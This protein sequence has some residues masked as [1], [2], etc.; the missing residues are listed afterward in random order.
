MI[1]IIPNYHPIL[2]HFTVA[3]FSTSLG[4]H[5]LNYLGAKTTRIQPELT[6]EFATVGRWCLWACAIATLLTITAGLHAYYTVG[7]D[8]VSHAAMT[9]HRNWAIPTA[10][11][12]WLIAIWSVLRHLKKKKISLVFVIALLIVQAL[13]LSTAWRGAELVYRYGL[14]V[15]ALPQAEE[16]GHQHENMTMHSMTNEDGTSMNMEEHDRSSDSHE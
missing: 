11:A 13:V 3:L 6:E 5:V 1:E 9:K 8:A 10:I 16:V 15:M 14:G 2:V 12:I 7:H 4:F